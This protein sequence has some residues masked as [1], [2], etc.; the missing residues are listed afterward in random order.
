MRPRTIVLAGLAATAAMA[1]LWHGP[2]GNGAARLTAQTEARAQFTL[3]IYEMDRQV[4]AVMQREPVTRRLW[5]VGTGDDFQQRE[6]K[7]LLDRLPAVGDVQWW[8]EGGGTVQGEPVLPLIAEVELAA[9]ASFALG[10]MIAYF[11]A[12]RRHARRYDI[13]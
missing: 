8:R 12:L 4:R 13:I 11:H 2:V 1:A 10:I 7:L 5:L 3:E 9:L 6:L